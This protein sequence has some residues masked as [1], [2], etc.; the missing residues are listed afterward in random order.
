MK[1]RKKRQSSDNWIMVIILKRKPNVMYK[2]TIYGVIILKR[3]P[4]VMYTYITYVVA[5]DYFLELVYAQ[6]WP[7]SANER[8]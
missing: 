7:K 1:R 3:K 5:S 2:Y 8:S 6:R 4:N